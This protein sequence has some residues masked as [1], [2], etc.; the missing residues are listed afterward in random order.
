MDQ[1]PR[2]K[3]HSRGKQS[4]KGKIEMKIGRPWYS[5]YFLS[6]FFFPDDVFMH[7]LSE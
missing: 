4:K 2:F 3:E 1:E 7:T 5:N 6:V